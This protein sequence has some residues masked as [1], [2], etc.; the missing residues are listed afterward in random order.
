[1]KAYSIDLR[2]R[3]LAERD[4]GAE[5]RETAEAFDVSE[6]FIWKLLQRR[7]ATGAIGPKPHPGRTPTWPA[8]ADRIRE[9]VERTPDATLK[10][11]RERLN[12]PISETTLWRALKAM[13]LTLKKSAAGRRAGPARREG[14]ARRVAGENPRSGRGS[15][16]L[17]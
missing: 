5:V 14:E 8:H 15:P 9:G 12:L 10:E 7:S 1:V 17:H 6:S 3:V 4:G 11:L 16:C 13:K 2:V